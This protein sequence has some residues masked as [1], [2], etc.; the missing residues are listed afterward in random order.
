MIDHI[1]SQGEDV[2]TKDFAAHMADIAE[3]K[4]RT[5]KQN[6]LLR[7][8]VGHSSKADG[9]SGSGNERKK[10]GRAPAPEA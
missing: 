1:L 7:E 8:E 3:K 2:T 5:L 9:A 4:A 10:M 6:R